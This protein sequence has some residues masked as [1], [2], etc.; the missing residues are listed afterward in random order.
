MAKRKSSLD[1]FNFVYQ[2]RNKFVELCDKWPKRTG[3]KLLFPASQAKN[4]KVTVKL[5]QRF[6]KGVLV[7]DDKDVPHVVDFAK[8][9]VD[10]AAQLTGTT[11]RPFQVDEGLFVERDEGKFKS[12][13]TPAAI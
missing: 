8:W 11:P 6:G 10:K 2:V 3:N 1:M 12:K 9:L 5:Y 4:I 7:H 13:Q